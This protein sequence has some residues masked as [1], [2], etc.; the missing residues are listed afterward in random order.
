MKTYKACPTSPPIQIAQ[1][2]VSAKPLQ[3]D[4]FHR[5]LVAER[6]YNTHLLPKDKQKFGVA[7]ALCGVRPLMLGW[8]PAGQ[9]F[10]CGVCVRLAA[11]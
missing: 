10:L 8:R 7:P 6:S 9:Q 2:L 5:V 4:N 3:T 1:G 11:Q